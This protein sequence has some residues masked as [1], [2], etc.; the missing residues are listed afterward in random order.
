MNYRR[1]KCSQCKNKAREGCV[2]C[3]KPLCGNHGTKKQK[4][5]TFDFYIPK[6]SC[7]ICEDKIT[8][9]WFEEKSKAAIKWVKDFINTDV[10]IDSSD[11]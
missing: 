5:F 9:K 1:F 6:R 10:T 8:Q 4:T 11:W 2:V 3:A 7:R